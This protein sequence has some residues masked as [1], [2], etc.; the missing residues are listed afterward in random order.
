M[1]EEDVGQERT[2]APTPR[3]REEARRQGQIAVSADL[4]TGVM[5]LAAAI[6]LAVAARAIGGGLLDGVRF[7]LSRP[8][9]TNIDAGLAQNI[10]G[11]VFVRTLRTLAVLL[12]TL[13]V[14]AV[15]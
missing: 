14:A 9:P 7:D 15:L 1:A 11:G 6:V 3:R 8:C 13:V 10:V 12:A 4:N 5:L 2:E